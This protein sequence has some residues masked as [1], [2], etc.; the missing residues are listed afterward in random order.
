MHHPQGISTNTV[1]YLMEAGENSAAC[2]SRP[3]QYTSHPTQNDIEARCLM[4]WQEFVILVDTGV[5]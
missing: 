2:I 5:S 1:S 3:Q 4:F